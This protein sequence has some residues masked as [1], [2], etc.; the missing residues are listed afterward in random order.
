VLKTFRKPQKIWVAVLVTNIK[1]YYRIP[2]DHFLLFA[3][4]VCS[5]W[6]CKLSHVLLFTNTA[7]SYLLALTVCR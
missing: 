5:Y 1:Q 4:F 7:G 3:I 6:T 2:K